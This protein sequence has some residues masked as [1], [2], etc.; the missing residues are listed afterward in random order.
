MRVLSTV[1]LAVRELDVE[2]IVTAEFVRLRAE[3]E[4]PR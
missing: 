2:Q 4:A 3:P 1:A